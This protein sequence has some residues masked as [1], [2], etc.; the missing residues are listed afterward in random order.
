MGLLAR[1][2]S[3][4]ALEGRGRIARAPLSGGG[5]A[6][7][8]AAFV[9]AHPLLA[10][11]GTRVLVAAASRVEAVP[12]GGGALETVYRGTSRELT[13]LACD[14]TR[15]Y[16][17]DATGNV[18]AIPLDGS[19]AQA[20]SGALGGGPA[21]PLAVGDGEVVWFE[22]GTLRAAPVGGGGAR[23]VATGLPALSALAV[24]V[25]YLA[26]QASG[27]VRA[28]PLAGG[29]SAVLAGGLPL[30]PVDLALDGATLRWIDPA[31]VG[32]VDLSTGEARLLATGL[33]SDLAVPNR[34]ASGAGLFWTEGGSGDLYSAGP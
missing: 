31:H 3:L 28:V 22:G 8:V 2:R 33:A 9:S 1:G 13:S 29:E 6:T 21:A 10:S 4:R 20:L 27:L 14:G 23:T 12:L 7:L 32:E 17:G 11:D 15:A 26:E 18:F 24:G 5:Q 19:P 25:A 16:A 30:A 34:I